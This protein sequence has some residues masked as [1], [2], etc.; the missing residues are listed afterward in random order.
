[1]IQQKLG[2][3]RRIW[4]WDCLISRVTSFSWFAREFN[5]FCTESLTSWKLTLPPKQ[6]RTVGD[7]QPESSCAPVNWW[8]SNISPKA[9]SSGAWHA[10]LYLIVVNEY[11]WH[12]NLVLCFVYGKNIFCCFLG[13]T[14]SLEL[15][16]LTPAQQL[17]PFGIISNS[18]PI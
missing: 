17:S 9:L 2:V 14:Y 8:V 15:L 10:A 5:S 13:R 1:M 18:G 11:L 3:S 7:E 12:F 6:T 4:S 16:L